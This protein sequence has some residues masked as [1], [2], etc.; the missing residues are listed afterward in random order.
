MFESTLLESTLALGD[1][2]VGRASYCDGFITSLA[3]Q[4]R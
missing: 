2:L 1:H 3:S 4:R